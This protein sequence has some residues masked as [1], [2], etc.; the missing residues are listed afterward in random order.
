MSISLDRIQYT[1]EIIC[2]SFLLNLLNDGQNKNSNIVWSFAVNVDELNDK[3]TNNMKRI[4]WK[5]QANWYKRPIADVWNRSCWSWEK[6]CHQRCSTIS[7]SFLQVRGYNMGRK[8]IYVHCNYWMCICDSAAFLIQNQKTFLMKW[9][10]SGTKWECWWLM[11][12]HFQLKIKWAN[13]ILVSSMYDE[14]NPMA[15]K[16][17]HSTWSLVDIHLFSVGF[18]ATPTSESKR[19]ST[20]IYQFWP[21][22][23]FH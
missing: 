18:L 15:M 4:L 17:Y 5:D 6:D 8:N 22:W 19:E 20:V 3:T 2:S 11:K 7:F 12:F 21:S 14:S 16:F 1:Y 13:W 10:K 9:Q 23:E